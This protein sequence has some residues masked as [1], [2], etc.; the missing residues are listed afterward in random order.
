MTLFKDGKGAAFD[1][2]LNQIDEFKNAAASEQFENSPLH[3]G[4]AKELPPLKERLPCKCQFDFNFTP[5]L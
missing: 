4:P 5:A 3:L 2:P 1:V